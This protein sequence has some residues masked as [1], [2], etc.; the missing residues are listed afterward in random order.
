VEK[1]LCGIVDFLD[2]GGKLLMVKSVLAS[3]P[4]SFMACLEIP[5]AIKEQIIKFMRHCLW[6]KKN[7]DV[8][9]KGP[10]L[11]AWSTVC[12]P[13]DQGGLGVLHLETQNNALLLKNLHKFYNK[14]DIPWVNLVWSSYYTQ[15]HLPGF[16]MEGSFWWKSHIKLIDKFKGISRC[17]IGDGKSALFWTDLWENVCMT[18]K[19]PHLLS[20]AKSTDLTVYQVLETEFLEDLFHL[21]LSQE[22]FSEFEDLEVLCGRIISTFQQ[23]NIDSWSY[24]WG[25]KEF[26]TKQA[27]KALMGTQIVP[28]HF[29]WLWKTSCQARHK[30]FF[31]LL[32]HDRLNTRNLLRRKD[33]IIQSYSC[34]TLSCNQEETL[35]HL[36]LS[37]PFAS[38][39]WDYICPER[40]MDLSIMEAI[41]DIKQKI[42]EPFSMD[43]IILAAWSIWIVRN[44][45]FFNNDSPSLDSWKAIL[46][47]ELR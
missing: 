39:C 25:S 18:Q 46:K 24:I 22:A 44:N 21:P 11:I 20:F 6:R 30:F 31:W 36:F 33:F 40:T 34:V 35:Q 15:G 13:K 41:I 19:F 4:I 43:I 42:N 7:N 1:R 23:G 26:T 38:A 2:Y 14:M 3:L 28:V 29:N 16:K 37:C 12:K 17:H 5:V 47:Q 45:K 8:Q 9:S 27:Y 32:L 10:A